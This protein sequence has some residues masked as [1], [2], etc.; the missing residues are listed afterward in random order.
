MGPDRHQREKKN[1]PRGQTPEKAP[2]A[3]G[4]GMIRNRVERGSSGD[5]R[6]EAAGN[7]R[8]AAGLQGI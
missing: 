4:G 7:L 2:R 5:E 8:P 1:D 3:G 6:P